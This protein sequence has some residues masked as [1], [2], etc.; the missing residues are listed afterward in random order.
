MAVYIKW[1]DIIE[2]IERIEKGDVIY[3]VSDVTRLAFRALQEKDSYDGNVLLDKLIERIGPE[4]TLLVPTFNWDFCSGKGFDYYKTPSQTGALGNV[5]LKRADFKRT[6]H[7]I[8]SFAV[9]GKGKE[10]LCAMENKDA[11]GEGT[12]FSY[13]QDHCGKGLIIGLENTQG[14]TSKLHNEQVFGVPYR[15]IKDFSAPYTD[16]NGE[17]SERAYSMNVRDYDMDPQYV[18][19]Q[20]VFSRI[21]RDLNILRTQE[22]NGV[23]VSTVLLNELAQVEEVEIKC[24]KCRNMYTYKGQ[25]EA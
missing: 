18:R 8:Y 25:D 3:L 19:P 9:W 5:A 12:P 10:E 21:L 20:T 11:W 6:K 15:Y 17:T 4:G 2:N 7:P 1:N 22:I 24:N 13:M 14:L 16:E 23:P